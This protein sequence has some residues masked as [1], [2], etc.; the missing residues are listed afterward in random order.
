MSLGLRC[1]TPARRKGWRVTRTDRRV[2]AIGLDGATLDLIGPWAAEGKLPHL[3]RIMAEGSYGT[4]RSTIPPVTGPAW[5]SFMTGKNPGKHGVGDFL[6]RV[7][8]QYD[9]APVNSTSIRAEPFWV[10]AGRFGKK[11]GILNVPVTYPPY[12][13]NGFLVSGLLTPRNTD[14]FTYPPELAAELQEAIGGY[15]V[16]LDHFYSEGS[17]ERF[18]SDLRDLVDRRTRAAK[19]LR[20]RYEWDFFMVHYIATDWVQHFLWHCMDPAHPRYNEY[21]AQAYGGAIL[22]LYRQIDDAVGELTASLDQDT[23]VLVMSDHGFGPFHKYIYLNNWL[24]ENGLLCLKQGFRTRLK[25]ALFWKGITPSFVYGVLDKLGGVRVAF[26][27]SKKQRHDLLST[28]FLSWKDID[29]TRTKAYSFGNVGQVFIN[30]RGR[31]PQGIV[32]PGTEYEELRE[33]IVSMLSELRD[34]EKG[35]QLIE[36]V[37]RREEVYSGDQAEDLADLLMLPLNMEYGATGL[38]AFVSNEVVEPSFAYSGSH[39]MEGVLMLKG[40]GV[41]RGQTTHDAQIV[42]MAPTILHLLGLPV[43]R[44]MDGRVLT[45]VLDERFL[46]SRRIEYTDE[47]SEPGSPERGLSEEEAEQVT[48][49]LRGLGYVT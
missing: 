24:L 4:L 16:N 42:D 43:S 41:K 44:D 26:K 8:G 14:G 35:A 5:T 27:A 23:V 2:F 49:R 19:H 3:A 10:T 6:H 37:Y 22:D 15:R 33:Q 28:F 38:S 39:R 30:L 47:T 40:S 32:E 12:E 17:G 31:E 11:V 48:E 21:E 25:Q 13:V 7:S 20:D 9:R 1:P 34:P 36:H 46:A 29:W 45:E 18:L